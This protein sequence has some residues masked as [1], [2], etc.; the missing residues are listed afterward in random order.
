MTASVRRQQGF[1]LAAS[2]VLLAALTGCA[3][4]ST[5]PVED[6]S[7]PPQDA[8]GTVEINDDGTGGAWIGSDG[9]EFAV[10]VSGSSTCPPVATGY[11]VTGN[12][13]ITVTLAEIPADK[14][15][16]ADFV[17]HTTVFN[18][19]DGFDNNQDLGVTVGESTFTI[20]ALE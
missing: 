2:A 20:P 19:P 3:A 15:C 7:G 10:T 14:A 16:T 13:A 18:T 11:S 6:Y 4:S 5:S 8:T 12:N 1:A 9:S 17:P